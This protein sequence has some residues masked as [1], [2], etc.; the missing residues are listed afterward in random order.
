MCGIVGIFDLHGDPR[1]Q[2]QLAIRLARFHRE[3]SAASAEP[4]GRR[5]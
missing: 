4:T 5:A 2:R 1:E 3:I